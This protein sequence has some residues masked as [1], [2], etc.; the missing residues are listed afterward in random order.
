MKDNLLSMTK[1]GTTYFHYREDA[2]IIL[3]ELLPDHPHA[4][5][6]EFD[7]GW[8]VHYYNCGPYYPS[9]S[10][11]D[12]RFNPKNWEVNEIEPGI[13]AIVI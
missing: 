1:N 6:V 2:E 4:K 12:S 3:Q 9:D 8:A 7:L 13:T 11:P 5:I 10:L